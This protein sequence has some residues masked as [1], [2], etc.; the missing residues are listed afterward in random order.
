LEINKS[1]NMQDG[2]NLS[3]NLKN[4]TTSKPSKDVPFVDLDL[5]AEE[6]SLRVGRHDLRTGDIL[7]FNNTHSC[8][9]RFI[10]VCSD[11]KYSHVALVVKDPTFGPHNLKGLYVLEST[12]MTKHADVEDHKKKWGVQLRS[13]ED[14]LEEENCKVY[15]RLLNC[16]RDND[17]FKRLRDVHS[18]VHNKP[19]DLNPSDWLKALFDFHVGKLER[20]REFFCSALVAFVYTAWGFLPQN[21]PWSI[22][23][24]K[25][26]GSNSKRPLHFQN[27]TLNREVLYRK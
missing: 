8:L 21:T 7:L 25:D 13:L 2:Q 19:Y 4:L 27:C 18:L 22:V 12:G 17:F 20:T 9:S 10:E 11:S 3:K 23:R 15:V 5:H 14:V 1:A 24:P 26:W 16:D 6:Q